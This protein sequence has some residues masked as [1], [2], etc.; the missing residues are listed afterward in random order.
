MGTK[1]VNIFTLFQTFKLK[2]IEKTLQTLSERTGNAKMLISGFDDFRL[3][4]C[5]LFIIQY[6]FKV[7]LII[8]VSSVYM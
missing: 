4:V 6:N 2:T 5:L 1:H 3:H 7:D 8:S